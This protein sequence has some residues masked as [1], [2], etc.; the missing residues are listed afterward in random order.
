MGSAKQYEAKTEEL[1]KPITDECGVRIYDV[2]WVKEGSDYYLR[3][4]IDKDGGV[5]IDD[6][7]KVSRAFNEVLD[8]EDYIEEAYIFEVSSPGL[9]RTLKKDRHLQQSIGEEVEI[10]F[11]KPVEDPF[12]GSAK[13]KELIGVLK[14]FTADAVTVANEAGAEAQILRSDIAKISLTLDF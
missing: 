1:L 2:E 12:G 13:C 14:G 11:Y 6:C 4:Y 5:D 9:G 8:R 3:A 7:E 10:R